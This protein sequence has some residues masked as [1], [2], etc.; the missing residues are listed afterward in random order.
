MSK[1]H[2]ATKPKDSTRFTNFIEKEQSMLHFLRRIRRSL[3]GTGATRKYLAY[4]I[5]EVILVMVGI[6]LAL[7]VN[8]WNETRTGRNAAIVHCQDLLKDLKFDS[9]NLE[10]NILDV[11]RKNEWIDSLWQYLNFGSN[12][13]DS[14]YMLR[15]IAFAS[16]I[17]ESKPR[18]TSYDNFVTSGNI[19]FIKNRTIVS[20]LSEYHSPDGYGEVEAMQLIDY[21]LEY[22]RLRTKVIGP[23]LVK[24]LA[25]EASK[26]KSTNINPINFPPVDF[27]SIKNDQSYILVL[28]N[29]MTQLPAF[30]SRL[31]LKLQKVTDL[32][33][34]V[35]M[36]IG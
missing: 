15:A 22:R 23:V 29:I 14:F 7:Q 19:K 24:K 32:I 10:K 9:I 2:L 36:E 13:V 4:A 31:H 28:G 6:L 11:Q 17:T 8:N 34:E 12:E 20:L 26:I 33:D 16:V 30:S 1:V 21:L 25:E 5:G 27:D 3:I 18:R 35:R